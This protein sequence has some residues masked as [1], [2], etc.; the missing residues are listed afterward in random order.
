MLD[1]FVFLILSVSDTIYTAGNCIVINCVYVLC[2]AI[3][4]WMKVDACW[5]F[6]YFVSNV[7]V[8]H[9]ALVYT[10]SIFYAFYCTLDE[11]IAWMLIC[12]IIET[13]EFYVS[14]LFQH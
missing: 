8:M 1:V 3:I 2:I 13:C 6:L 4:Y 7:S 5:M 11:L 10:V 12:V 9:C 14:D